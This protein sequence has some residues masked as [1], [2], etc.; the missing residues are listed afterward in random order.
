[1][2]KAI[3]SVLIPSAVLWAASSFLYAEQKDSKATL[4]DRI[5]VIAH[6]P[7]TGWACHAANYCDSLAAELPLSAS[8]RR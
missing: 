3:Q 6:I 2:F 5:D 8:R 7:G 1:M 4:V